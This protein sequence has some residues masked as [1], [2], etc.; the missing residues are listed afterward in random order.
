[1]K[2]RAAITTL[3]LTALAALAALP[4]A[5]LA[6][7]VGGAAA[8]S[9]PASASRPSIERQEIRAQLLPRRYTTIAAEV[10]AKIARLPV[11]EGGAFKAGQLL[12]SFDCSL[13]QSQLE[14]AQAEYESAEQ[15]QKS[16]Q[17]L[18]ELNSVGELD[19]ALSRAALNKARAEVS[20]NQAVLNKCT[21]AAPFSGRITEQKAREQQFVQPG[22]A[23]L[24]I[25]DDSSLELEFLVPSSW[26]VWL[27]PGHAFQIQIDET[28][29]SYPARFIR[30]G[31]RIDPVSQSIKVTAA[32]DGRYPELIAGMSGRAQISPPAEADKATHNAGSATS[33]TT[34]NTAAKPANKP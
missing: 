21:I 24:D 6:Q 3:S 31:A 32:I 33:S 1:M 5:A 11:P 27:R 2:L 12:V 8:V 15:T 26:L 4:A 22:Q 13:Q 20:A 16:N 7:S 10:G 25:M 34:G 9:A 28:R 19:L 30:L 18:S 17:R 14:K 23:L 29:K